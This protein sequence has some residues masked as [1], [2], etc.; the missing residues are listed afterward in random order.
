[1]DEVRL[2]YRESNICVRPVCIK[3]ALC[4]QKRGVA[5]FLPRVAYPLTYDITNHAAS[6]RGPHTIKGIEDA[7]EVILSVQL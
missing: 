1:M 4:R 2:I 3:S 7:C 5:G 6:M